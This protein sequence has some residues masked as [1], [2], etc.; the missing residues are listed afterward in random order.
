MQ[1]F[2]SSNRDDR[3]RREAI[4]DLFQED[5]SSEH[6]PY[7]FLSNS[8]VAALG[9][10]TNWI[11]YSKWVWCW[12]SEWKV[13]IPLSGKSPRSAGA[14]KQ[15]KSILQK[16]ADKKAKAESSELLFVKPRKNQR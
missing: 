7:C 13:V 6:S 9:G 1:H 3:F 16:R 12:V 15:G 11:K 4:G 8:T 10:V 5:I 2:Y 14:K